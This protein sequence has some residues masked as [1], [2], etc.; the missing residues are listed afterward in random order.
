MIPVVDKSKN[1]FTIVEGESR[2][3]P[4]SLILSNKDLKTFSVQGATEI[5]ARFLDAR[6]SFIELY[7]TSGDILEVDSSAG[8]IAIVISS[9]TSSQ[10]MS[11]NNLDFEVEVTFPDGTVRISQFIGRLNVKDRLSC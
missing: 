5:T 1:V 9:L 7:K 4:I 8:R 11:G 3:I 2:Q 10:M 6:S